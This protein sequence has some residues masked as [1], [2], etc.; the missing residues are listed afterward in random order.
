[1]K[2]VLDFLRMHKD[3]YSDY[4]IDNRLLKC[5]YGYTC[6]IDSVYCHLNK[7]NIKETVYFNF[8]K[9]TKKLFDLKK[10]T[11]LEVGCGYIPILSS[12]YKQNGFDV[13]AVDKKIL[14]KNY[15]QVHTIEFDLTKEFDL[16]NYHLIVGLRPCT[17]TENVI[18]LCYRYHKSFIIYL[19]P[20]IH[21]PKNNVNINAY[22]E[23]INYL[24]EKTAEFQNYN[25][26]FIKVKTMPDDC[27]VVIGKYIPK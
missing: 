5:R 6:E 15:K 18:E 10:G 26:S 23:W 11:I 9:L 16:S 20:C 7:I 8:Y 27:P 19:C 22:T 3:Y 21:K 25:I 17:I 13:D 24:K 2:E 14:F 12:I 4:F 1:M